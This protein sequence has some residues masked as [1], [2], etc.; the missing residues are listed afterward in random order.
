V[1]CG[2]GQS[3]TRTKIITALKPGSLP[4]IAN[5]IDSIMDTYL[6]LLFWGVPRYLWNPATLQGDR[7]YFGPGDAS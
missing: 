3:T 6:S 1:E 2:K 4:A 5:F 7:G